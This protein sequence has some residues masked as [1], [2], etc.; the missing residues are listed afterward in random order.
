ML[1]YTLIKYYKDF[2]GHLIVKVFMILSIKTFIMRTYLTDVPYGQ[3]EVDSA[4]TCD[5]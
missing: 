4:R 1:T 3:K 2:Y 5:I